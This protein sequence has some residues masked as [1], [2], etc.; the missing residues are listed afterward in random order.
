MAETFVEAAVN[1]KDGSGL[2][3]FVLWD[4][5]V[6][7]NWGS[8]RV[9]DG[10]HALQEWGFSPT[11]VPLLS[12]GLAPGTRIDAA[13]KGR[14]DYS[15]Y[16]YFF[17]DGK[18]ARYD[19]GVPGVNP[20]G[21]TDTLTGWGLPASFGNVDAAFNG[22]A[23][24]RDG[25]AYFFR[26]SKYVR[27]SW[28]GNGS[29]DPGYADGKEIGTMVGMAGL[30]YANGIDAAVDG[31]GPYAGIGYLFKEDEYLRFTWNP[32]E[33]GEPRVDG[34]SAKIAGNWPGLVE[35]LA[36]GKAKAQGLAWLLTA[37]IQLTAYA[38]FLAG[39][40]YLF[41]QSLMETALSKHFHINPADS[42]ASKLPTIQSILTGLTNIAT[43]LGE[44]KTLFAFKTDAQAASEGAAGIAAYFWAVDGKMSFTPQFITRGPFYRAAV[45]L[46]ESVH[47]FDNQSG[48]SAT[49]IPEWY[50]TAPEAAALGLTFEPDRPTTEFA[51]RYDLMT[52]ANSLHN[53]SSYAAFCQ[54][55]F[56]VADT[57]YG[58][59]HPTL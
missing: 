2:A 52:T 1:G 24:T 40:P 23:P 33:G 51:T 48:T 17:R 55:I 4:H 5:Y 41:N 3:Y 42:A 20:A 43:A 12:P 32:S 9:V 58:D 50:V 56:Y 18:Y 13:L 53:A 15:A 8:N 45:V 16:S 10:V 31:D 21:E 54:H 19:W 35:L 38:A 47:V 11:F 27:Y 34:A 29:V 26:G 59:G 46:H 30:P 37:Q 22:Q 25:K 49:H 28:A 14:K 7:F 44:S 57:R 6:A 39:A 36:A